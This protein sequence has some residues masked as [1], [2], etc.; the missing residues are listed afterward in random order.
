TYP[1]HFTG[2]Y[3]LADAWL[4]SYTDIA[5]TFDRC[6]PSH[7]LHGVRGA[8]GEHWVVTESVDGKERSTQ[9]LPPALYLNLYHWNLDT[10]QMPP[11][12]FAFIDDPRFL[13]LEVSAVDGAPVDWARE[14]RVAV[15]L[16]HLKLV[17]ATPTP[18]GTRLRFEAPHLPTG[19]TVAF[20]AF[21]P[22]D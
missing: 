15:G 9:T 20:F 1:R 13:E 7:C 19:L 11:G 5:T 2:A 8:D 4:P 16:V 3:D 18:R 17:G 12:S 21:G 6:E 22:D 10:A 14:V